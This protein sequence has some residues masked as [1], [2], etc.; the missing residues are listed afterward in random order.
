MSHLDAAQR[1]ALAQLQGLIH[2]TDQEVAISVLD[3]VGWDVQRAVDLIF[4]PTSTSMRQFEIDDSAVRAPQPSTSLFQ[5]ARPFVSV[6]AFPLHVLSNI[7]RFIFG[8]LRIP[9][10]HFNFSTLS[11]YRSLPR[12]PPRPS[13]GGPD[14][15]VRELEEETG[16]VS[17][18][19]ARADATTTAT[20]TAGPS[21]LTA[22]PRAFD[23]SVKV[24]PD[25]TLGSYDEAL[26]IC[27][28][29]ARIGCIVL[30]SEEH[31]DV[32]EFKR[33]TLTDPN[34]VKLLH[35]NNMV[36]WGGDVRDQE[37]WS[38]AAKLQATTYPFVAFVAP[39]PRRS[40]ASSS[41]S[42]SSTP[43][44]VLTVLS[45]H[46]G[47]SINGGPTSAHTLSAHLTT[48]LLPRV[49]PFLERIHQTQRERE[50]DRRLR[51][52]QDRA[53]KETARRDRERIESKMEEERRE[54]ERLH[55]VAE[56]E[57]RRRQR[58]EE[59]KRER[60][61]R[62]DWR[63][64]ERRVQAGL[65]EPAKGMRVAVRLPSG[66]RV[67]RTFAGEQTL[68]AL[69]AFVDAQLVPAGMDVQ[70]DPVTSPEG[71]AWNTVDLEKC[72]EGQIAKA[73]DAREWWGFQL[74]LAYPRK[75][76]PWEGGVRLAEVEALRGGGQV[77]VEMVGNGKGSNGRL[78]EDAG[79][80]DGY[81][82]ES[83]GE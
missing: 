7:F 4:D 6:L 54:R 1:Q 30:V 77:V 44:P 31:D 45:R 55:L 52:E 40:P 41:S 38:A 3:S 67:I 26:R 76:I 62:M 42:R 22:R 10:P 47:P 63:R 27:Q 65:K 78:S 56:E 69:Y 53:F 17:I 83:D 58:E 37:A 34:F 66:G 12:R 21:T 9:F 48:Q 35:E 14:R 74:A 5:L 13:R 15:W 28:R 33:T 29:D 32:A 51:E 61:R 49:T 50:R 70:E 71:D 46:Q 39:Q 25:F 24:L 11:F 79:D 57:E 8:I 81:D 73:E 18:G 20:D 75:E 16:A 68:T 80:S 23:D 64:W 36:V 82:T 72:L 59:R 2:G 60:E 19:T 43:A